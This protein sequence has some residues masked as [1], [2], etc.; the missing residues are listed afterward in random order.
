MRVKHDKHQTKAVQRGEQEEG[1]ERPSAVRLC[2]HLFLLRLRQVPCESLLQNTCY[3]EIRLAIRIKEKHTS[4]HEVLEHMSSSHHT[5]RLP[6][7]AS[8][9]ARRACPPAL[10]RG[11]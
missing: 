9:A 4:R 2:F 11:P 1:S 8:A 7:A 3:R 6:P 10:L 5:C